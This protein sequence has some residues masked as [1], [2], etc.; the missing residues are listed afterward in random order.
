MKTSSTNQDL[1]NAAEHLISL[2]EEQNEQRAAELI[3]EG[4]ISLNGLTD[5][6]A[7]FLEKITLARMLTN[8]EIDEDTL[9]LLDNIYSSIRDIVYH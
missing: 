8:K 5:G 9:E 3:R 2:L 1:F 4:L 7:I 6:W